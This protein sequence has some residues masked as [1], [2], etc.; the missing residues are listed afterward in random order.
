M[1]WGND[2]GNG[3]WNVPPPVYKPPVSS[4]GSQS[5]RAFQRS[6]ARFDPNRILVP[7]KPTELRVAWPWG[8]EKRTES[9]CKLCAGRGKYKEFIRW[10]SCLTCSGSGQVTTI[11][12]T[13][14][15]PTASEI[16]S[17]MKKSVLVRSR[18]A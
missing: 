2:N 11:T 6:T 10:K 14:R 12:W 9:V 8:T 3:A 1:T 5:I 7:A 4:R 18:N 15:K 16:E 13:P 17:F